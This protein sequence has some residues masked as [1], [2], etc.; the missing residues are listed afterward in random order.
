MTKLIMTETK[1]LLQLKFVALIGTSVL[2]CTLVTTGT[3]AD[4]ERATKA[5]YEQPEFPQPDSKRSKMEIKLKKNNSL[6]KNL[7][8]PSQ[9]QRGE[10]EIG[11]PSEPPYSAIQTLGSLLFVLTLF[12]GVAYWMKRGG[13]RSNQLLS[14]EAWEILGRGNLGAKHDVQ[15]VRL[16]NRLLLV[17][18]S[19]N[20]IQTLVEITD[21]E[22]VQSMLTSC[23]TKRPQFRTGFPKK[24]FAA[25]SGK[26]ELAFDRIEQNTSPAYVEPKDA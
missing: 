13:A 21:P 16:G 1:I 20:T 5:T 14:N 6:D 3:A 11:S 10:K 23:H 9:S 17:G 7:V 18:Y 15:L 24:L 19:P 26:S 2:L 4:P 25:L 12:G 8:K 22:E